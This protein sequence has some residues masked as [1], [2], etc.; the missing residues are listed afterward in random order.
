[1]LVDL[2][3][4][5][6]VSLGGRIVVIGGLQIQK[7]IDIT[8]KLLISLKASK[9]S[10]VSAP[11]FACEWQFGKYYCRYRSRHSGSNLLRAESPGNFPALFFWMEYQSFS[12]FLVDSWLSCG[13][14]DRRVFSRLGG[15]TE[16]AGRSAGSGKAGEGPKGRKRNSRTEGRRP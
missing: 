16:T 10:G 2:K 4:G 7:K 13:G 1:L 12:S 8:V 3:K 14:D 9:T 15:E 11:E 5:Q 6:K